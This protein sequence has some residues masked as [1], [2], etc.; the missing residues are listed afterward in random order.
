MGR[1]F[2]PSRCMELDARRERRSPT[3]RFEIDA[4]Y[5]SPYPDAFAKQQKLYICEYTLKYMK[6]RKVRSERKIR[7]RGT[8]GHSLVLPCLPLSRRQ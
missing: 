4:W 6:R 8:L 2:P 5:F 3:S 7:W 1:Y